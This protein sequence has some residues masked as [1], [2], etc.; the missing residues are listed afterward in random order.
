VREAIRQRLRSEPD[1][2]EA[3]RDDAEANATTNRL[4]A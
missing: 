3:E 4:R 2:D 1:A